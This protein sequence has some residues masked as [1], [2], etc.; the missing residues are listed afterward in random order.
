MARM[1]PLR[2]RLV[3]IA[4]LLALLLEF[5]PRPIVSFGTGVGVGIIAHGTQACSDPARRVATITVVTAGGAVS[6]LVRENESIYLE[7]TNALRNEI[8]DAGGTQ[9]DY[10]ARVAEINE[11]FDRRTRALA[12]TS[13]ALYG[14]AGIIDATERGAPATQYASAAASVLRALEIALPE[15]TREQGPLRGLHIPSELQTVLASLRGIAQQI[16]ESRDH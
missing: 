1:S 16:G 3:Q 11:A 14:A 15:L 13:A 8:A 4:A 9:R 7:A 12:A 10:G 6:S 2:L 5:L